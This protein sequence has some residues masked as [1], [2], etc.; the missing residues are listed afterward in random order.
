MRLVLDKGA[1]I[2]AKDYY[3]RRALHHAAATSLGGCED[4]VRLLLDKGANASAKDSSGR[5]PLDLVKVRRLERDK[6]FKDD[7][8]P[9]VKKERE[10]IE[11]IIRLLS[12]DG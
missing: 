7:G 10:T 4:T 5:T 11:A 1:D 3:R 2:E 9:W 12:P 6:A 8:S